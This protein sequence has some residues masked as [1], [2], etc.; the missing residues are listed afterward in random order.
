MNNDTLHILWTNDNPVTAEQMVF[1]YATNSLR[2]KWWSEVH[3][4]IWGENTRQVCENP[5]L[6]ELLLKFIE[7]GGSVSACRQC[8]ENLGVTGCLEQIAGIEVI[9][10]GEQ[11]TRILKG[12]EKL[13]SI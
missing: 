7:T 9:Y 4:I 11:L 5:R 13:I 2:L 1:M 3:L 8:A 10:M 12:G 6:K